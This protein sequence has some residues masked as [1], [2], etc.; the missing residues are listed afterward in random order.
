[1]FIVDT[2]DVGTSMF[3]KGQNVESDIDFW[4][5]DLRSKQIVFGLPKFSGGKAQICEAC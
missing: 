2:N 3:T 4:L 1:M 5:Q